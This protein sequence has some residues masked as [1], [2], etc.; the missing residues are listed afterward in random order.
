[1]KMS[2]SVDV[3]ILQKQ[4]KKTNESSKIGRYM[5]LEKSIAFFCITNNQSGNTVKN[6]IFTTANK[7]YDV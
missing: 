6:K 3:I 4:K 5:N 1:M 2:L 7:N